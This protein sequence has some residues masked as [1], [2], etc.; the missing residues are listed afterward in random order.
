MKATEKIKIFGRMTWAIPMMGI[1]HYF[2]LSLGVWLFGALLAR[3][4]TIETRALAGPSIKRKLARVDW[5]KS[6]I[7]PNII[8]AI[9][10]ALNSIQ[11]SL[12]YSAFG[13]ATL[14]YAQIILNRGINIHVSS[15]ASW[16]RRLFETREAISSALS[17]EVIFCVLL[18]GLIFW[19]IT[20][21]TRPLVWIGNSYKALGVAATVLGAASSFT[22][23]TYAS[24]SAAADSERQHLAAAF[25]RTELELANARRQL[26]AAGWLAQEIWQME[27]RQRYARDLGIIVTQV[28]EA[29]TGAREEFFAR[30]E[31]AQRERL[32]RDIRA[33]EYQENGD[34]RSGRSRQLSMHQRSLATAANPDYCPLRGANLLLGRAAIRGWSDG[35]PSAHPV[36]MLE[37][38]PGWGVSESDAGWLNRWRRSHNLHF[39]DAFDVLTERRSEVQRTH[40]AANALR[41]LSASMLARSS[42]ISAEGFWDLL[43]SAMIDA[44][45][46]RMVA[47]AEELVGTRWHALV[48]NPIQHA[49]EPMA[50]NAIASSLEAPAEPFPG[51]PAD[52]TALRNLS[53]LA[54]S[55][56]GPDAAWSIERLAAAVNL[57][58]EAELAEDTR[59]A[60][61]ARI[62]RLNAQRHQQRWR[63]NLLR[64]LR[65]AI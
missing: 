8:Q 23:V 16:E 44:T 19:L 17:F 65:H 27:N 54:G 24:N 38:A 64:A 6:W 15:I 36:P 4:I 56:A 32:A 61:Q 3:N 30:H 53:E 49:L 57:R 11:Q 47:T 51:R 25:R 33:V 13:I 1:A 43:V 60:R 5:G 46:E 34:H 48:S 31:H 29:C 37:S 14:L 39:R 9:R 22:F 2:G 12:I 18:L 35:K 58:I 10:S 20:L 41:D 42:G 45:A 63:R 21:K 28:R 62:G 59:R 50:P 40:S 7:G 52:G 55:E 26:S